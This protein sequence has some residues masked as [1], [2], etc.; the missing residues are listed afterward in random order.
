VD[1]DR[2]LKLW[3]SKYNAKWFGGELPTDTV[4]YWKPLSADAGKSCPIF[5]VADGKF[6]IN[7]DPKHSG[8]DWAWKLI[9]LHEMA[10]L[11]LWKKFPRHQHG[12]AFQEEMQRLSQAGALK[13]IW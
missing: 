8:T 12:K 3:Y 9:L 10:H 5:E 1:S 2:Q 4:I 6:E 7:I 11:K 13:G